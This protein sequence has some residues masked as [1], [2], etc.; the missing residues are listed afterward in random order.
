MVLIPH[1]C[2]L[3]FSLLCCGK[4]HSVVVSPHVSLEEICT[5]LLVASVVCTSI[6]VAVLSQLHLCML[7]LVE[8]KS[9]QI[10]EYIHCAFSV[11]TSNLQAGCTPC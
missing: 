8:Q 6:L 3:L 4:Q 7:F 9:P 2:L 1:A 11:M 10:S 5:D